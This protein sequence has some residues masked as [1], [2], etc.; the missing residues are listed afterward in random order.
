MLFLLLLYFRGYLFCFFFFCFN[1]SSSTSPSS[2]VIHVVV[3]K[4]FSIHFCFLSTLHIVLFLCKNVR[5]GF[6]FFF[7]VPL[8]YCTS[9][10]KV[11]TKCCKIERCKSECKAVKHLIFII[12]MLIIIILEFIHFINNKREWEQQQQQPSKRSIEKNILNILEN[13][14]YILFNFINNINGN[15]FLLYFIYYVCIYLFLFPSTEKKKKRNVKMKVT[16]GE[17]ERLIKFSW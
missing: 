16:V 11:Q 5:G 12:Q 7:Q 1:C 3:V 8:C 15:C 2:L 17:N 13:Q 4:V 6:H 10:I 14:R 9:K